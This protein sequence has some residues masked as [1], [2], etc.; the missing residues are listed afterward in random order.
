MFVTAAGPWPSFNIPAQ[1]GRYQTVQGIGAGL[2]AVTGDV[3]FLSFGPALVRGITTPDVSASGLGA[4]GTIEDMTITA[5]TYSINAS[6]GGIIR[7]GTGVRVEST[8]IG[9]RA[10]GTSGGQP[11]TVRIMESLTLQKNTAT[12]NHAML[13]EDDGVLSIEADVHIVHGSGSGYYNDI[14][15]A[16]SGGIVTGANYPTITD[17]GLGHEARF[18]INADGAAIVAFP[19]AI[20]IVGRGIVVGGAGIIAAD[21]GTSVQ[22]AA[23]T[24][25]ACQFGVRVTASAYVEITS[26]FHIVDSEKLGGVGGS[27]GGNGSM[28]HGVF[29]DF[30]GRAVIKGTIFENC[31]GSAVPGAAVYVNDAG[32]VQL[33]NGGLPGATGPSPSFVC[34]PCRI[35][36]TCVPSR[37]PALWA[38][39]A[40]STLIVRGTI[41]EDLVGG[42]QVTWNAN[43]G[44]IGVQNGASAEIGIVRG[45]CFDAESSGE[46]DWIDTGQLTQGAVHFSGCE[47]LRGGGLDVDA[48][49]SAVVTNAAF[50]GCRSSD[51]TPLTAGEGGSAIM[52]LGTLDLRL[53]FVD[54]CDS[55][56]ASGAVHTSGGTSNIL[57]STFRGNK[58]GAIYLDGS[59]NLVVQD[60]M[61]RLNEDLAAVHDQGGASASIVSSCFFENLAGD[62][63]GVAIGSDSV[64]EDPMFC[65]AADSHRRR[66]AAFDLF[67]EIRIDSVSPCMTLGTLTSGYGIDNDVFDYIAGCGGRVCGLCQPC[68]AVNPYYTVNT[69]SL[70]LCG[71]DGVTRAIG[72]VKM[73]DFTFTPEVFEHVR[74]DDGSLDALIPI[75]EDF[76]LVVTSDELTPQNLGYLL[77]Q[78][79]V[80]TV[81]GCEVAIDR[82]DYNRRF[83]AQFVHAF[84]CSDLVL[85][86]DFWASL[87]VG[88]ATMQFGE[89]P[90]AFPITIRATKCRSIHPTQPYGRLLFSQA[91][92]T[93]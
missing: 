90:L 51:V 85:Q 75:S 37:G 47:A 79:V 36:A 65:S 18:A 73:L 56:G 83:A 92:L 61:L 91:C 30:S 28:E 26:A 11:A 34:S 17:D 6:N 40:G 87:I 32:I 82:P 38:Y 77:G 42:S 88:N 46:I 8:G 9:I 50:V 33:D 68:E 15:R 22:V 21:A 43:G 7:V 86:I 29:A 27:L 84:P 5:G 35:R 23:L 69:G 14:I 49:S 41:L 63:S 62:A 71:P 72:N 74:G 66:D 31:V 24:C 1:P 81:E 53:S 55:D 16:T 80:Q 25:G 48:A 60:C 70:Y 13:V 19:G 39:G 67:Q 59:G 3:D 64:I 12:S 57:K 89:S 45:L 4:D 54:A 44:A 93:T 2:G 52:N 58:K 20:D 78:D 10:G 76:R